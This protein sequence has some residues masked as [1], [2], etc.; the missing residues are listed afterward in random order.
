MNTIRESTP[1]SV[2]LWGAVGDGTTDDTLA[3]QT[4]L[5]AMGFLIYPGTLYFP[6]GIYITSDQ[7]TYT[8]L[9]TGHGGK[10]IGEHETCTFIRY[11]GTASIS[12]VLKVTTPDTTY[13]IDFAI[14][15][16][17]IEGNGNVANDLYLNKPAHIN[18]D[19]VR[20]WGTSSTGNCLYVYDGVAGSYNQPSCDV[21]TDQGNPAIPKNGLVFD[22]AGG[23]DASTTTTILSP[24]VEGLTRL[25]GI[26]FWLKNAGLLIFTGCQT[27]DVYQV[28]NISSASAMNTFA[29]CLFENGTVPSY[30]GGYSNIIQGGVFSGLPL[31]TGGNLEIDGRQNTIS[32]V[33]I[34]GVTTVDSTASLAYLDNDLFDDYPVDNGLGTKIKNATFANVGAS[35]GFPQEVANTFSTATATMAGIN[36]AE[37]LRGQW[38]FGLGGTILSPT[39]FTTGK[40]WRAIF[41]GKFGFNSSTCTACEAMPTYTE[42]T[43]SANTVLSPSSATL[44][45]SVNS[46][47]FFFV[48]GGSGVETYQG[49][50]LFLPDIS[51]TVSG[52]NS[53]QLAGALTAPAVTAALNG[54]LG[55]TTP[56]TVAGT[57]GTFSGAVTASNFNGLAVWANFMGGGNTSVGLGSLPIT[58]TGTYNTVMGNGCLAS[59]TSGGLNT[60]VGVSALG[61]NLTGNYLTALGL[62]AGYY[63]SDGS[64]PNAAS[65]LSLY[66]GVDTEALASGDSNEVVI[67][68][69]AVGA[70]SN[71]VTLG[72]RGIGSTILRGTVNVMQ[73]IG[74]AVAPTGS[75]CSSGTWVF[76]QDG[77]ATFC[78]AGAW[79]TK[80]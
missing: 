19:K 6:C 31:T 32:E 70:G 62:N 68:P 75:G 45:F 1:V 3:I 76:S 52:A 60:C 38:T 57:T 9:S 25:G 8:T 41:I 28:L 34:Q 40:S 71:T 53:V 79:V 7:L 35:A 44:T 51:G 48:T 42:L 65:T 12:A 23:G 24:I 39:V 66:L 16:I 61:A 43:E 13:F 54:S 73:Q 26:G 47:G 4:A 33:E 49:T 36:G 37:T 56:N 21:A 5:N 55:A 69:Q 17:T 20:M 77:H 59:N 18:L 27:S 50:I 64:T 15:Y 2:K 78:S 11:T 58:T 14:R 30:I 22:G 63:I 46:N 80:I 29:N 10:I 72:N 74:P 67:G